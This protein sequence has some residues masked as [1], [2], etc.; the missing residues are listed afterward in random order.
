MKFVNFKGKEI[1]V[2]AAT[3]MEITSYGM[4]FYEKLYALV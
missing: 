1:L 2:V 4:Q 3:C